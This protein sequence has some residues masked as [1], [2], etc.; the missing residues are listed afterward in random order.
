MEILQNHRLGESIKI[1]EINGLKVHV[2]EKKQFSNIYASFVVKFGSNDISFKGNLDRNFRRYPL[3]IAHFLEHKMFDGD[4]SDEVFKKFSEIGADVN[5]YT[6]FDVTNYYFSTVENFESSIEQLCKMVYGI[7]LSD[8]SVEKEK[9]II[10][11]EIR[12]YDDDPYNRVYKNL[13]SKMY[14]EHPVKNDIA[15]DVNTI[16]QITKEHLMDCYNSF[17]SND[18]MFLIIVGNVDALNVK[19]ILYNNVVNK[20]NGK[21]IREKFNGFDSIKEH[22]IEENF[23]MKVPTNILG[24]KEMSLTTNYIKKLITFEI[25][26]RLYFRAT[27]DFYDRMYKSGIIDGSYYTE[28]RNGFD[29]GH[30]IL[31]GDGE[32]F[33]YLPEKFFEYYSKYDFNKDKVDFERIKK[34]MYGN[35]VNMFNSIENISHL[36]VKLMKNDVNVF[37]YFD[38]I[39][40]IK[41]EDVVYEFKNIFK[42]SNMVYSKVN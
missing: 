35:Y 27:S 3:G 12:M 18:N 25:I 4:G 39:N 40:K 7:K 30:Y 15:G 16:K 23:D 19:E 26:R 24:F 31:V 28:Y 8:E 33:K 6:S 9:L 22:Y 37:D 5:A 42:E 34:S 21:I 1:F 29:Y 41:L 38:E 32:K 11:Q 17:Y 14:D 20:Q 13:L 10:E 2:M 36:F